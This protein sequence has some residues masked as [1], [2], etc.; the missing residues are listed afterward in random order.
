[1]ISDNVLYC[2]GWSINHAY[3][4]KAVPFK[5]DWK[6]GRIHW[7]Q[8]AKSDLYILRLQFL[9]NIVLNSFLGFQVIRYVFYSDKIDF[10]VLAFLLFELTAYFC[11]IILGIAMQ[12]DLFE[13]TVF[14][15]QFVNYFQ[16]LQSKHLM[17]SYKL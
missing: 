17:S 3:R 10:S 2:F 6:T 13:Y 7:N 9:I 5:W 16:D 1:M 12:L 4:I 15:N 8:I 14:I 11:Y